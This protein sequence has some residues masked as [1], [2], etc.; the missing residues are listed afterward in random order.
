MNLE[1]SIKPISYVKTNAAEMIRQINETRNPIVITQNGEAKGVLV[2][3][4]TYQELTDALGLLKLISQSEGAAA[5]GDVQSHVDVI[6]AARTRARS[7]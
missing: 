5:S 3:P 6:V 2:D 7:R 4:T 1:A